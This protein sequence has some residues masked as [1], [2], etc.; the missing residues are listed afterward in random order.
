MLFRSNFQ[1]PLEHKHYSPYEYLVCGNNALFSIG[2]EGSLIEIPNFYSCGSGGELAL[3]LL[4]KGYSPTMTQQEA[5]TLMLEVFGN[6]S[7]LDVFTNNQCQIFGVANGEVL[8][9]TQEAP[10]KT[11]RGKA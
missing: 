5:A 1:L 6:V 7:S 3:S 2:C 8:S 11:K 4:Q 9:V 10:K